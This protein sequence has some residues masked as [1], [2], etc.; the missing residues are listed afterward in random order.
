MDLTFSCLSVRPLEHGIWGAQG[1]AAGVL[2]APFWAP[3]GGLESSGSSFLGVSILDH[4]LGSFG[5][6]GGGGPFPPQRRADW[7]V[8]GSPRQ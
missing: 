3:S 5:K 2:E 7:A 1:G 8:L 4:I 6:G